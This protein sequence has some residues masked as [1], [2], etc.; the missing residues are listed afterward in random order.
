MADALVL[1]KK[2][3]GKDAVILHTRV[4]KVGAIFGF[5]GKQQVEVTASVGVNAPA[6]GSSA[7]VPSASNA[8]NGQA[9]A[10][11]RSA[12][13]R[14]YGAASAPVAPSGSTATA[15]PAASIVEPK[16]ANVPAAPIVP[17]AVREVAQIAVAAAAP[18]ATAIAAPPRPSVSTISDDMQAELAAIKR[19]VGQVLQGTTAS[20]GISVRDDRETPTALVG[21]LP[22][23]PALLDHYVRLIEAEV[24]R[25]VADDLIGSLRD[26]LTP[27]ELK[28][29]QAVRVALLRKLESFFPT[30]GAPMPTPRSGRAC[31]I[32]LIGPTGVGKTTT[33]AKLAAAHKL[34]HGRKVGLITCD[35]YRIAAVEQLRTYANIIGVPL[36]VVLTPGELREAC[37]ELNSCDVILIDTAGRSPGDGARLDELRAFLHAAEPDQTHLVLSSTAGASSLH[38]AAEKFAALKPD[39]LLLTKLD[40]AVNFGL[41]VDIT[42]RVSRELDVRLSYVTTGQEVPDDIEPA[43]A[44]RMARLVL[45]GALP[46]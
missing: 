1:V 27:T 3:L 30:S 41:V 20:R 23:P 15:R 39:H 17:E 7:S 8:A 21:G 13:A 42:R 19:M 38:R 33:V 16:R 44:D 32:A 43:R 10:P 12:V 29:G 28:D 18:M 22:M 2:D 36:K 11:A 6:R 37:A 24:S 9:V 35:T 4:F 25:E 5:G 31:T 14:A 45:E 34:R 46:A 26:E 40:E